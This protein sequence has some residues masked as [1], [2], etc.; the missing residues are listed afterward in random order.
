MLAALLHLAH[1]QGEPE[2]QDGMRIQGVHERKKREEEF[3]IS[4]YT[5]NSRSTA[6]AAAMLINIFYFLFKFTFYF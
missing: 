6:H 4:I 1:L 2:Q 3:P 5:T